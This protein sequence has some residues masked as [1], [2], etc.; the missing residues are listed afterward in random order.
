MKNGSYVVK[1]YAAKAQQK[2]V[3]EGYRNVGKFWDNSSGM[4]PKP[5]MVVE[6]SAVARFAKPTTIPWNEESLKR[7]FDRTLRRYHEKC[8]NYDRTKQARRNKRRRKSQVIAGRA[9]LSGAFRVPFGT[10]IL[11][12]LMN[13]VAE[14][15][16]DDW[17][18]ARRHEDVVP[19]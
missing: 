8:M 10:K 11:V 3:P 2:E 4:N 17:A 1:Q 14:Y 6:P 5:D 13:Y 9:E 7:F 15:G 19:F 16:P 12:Q 18:I